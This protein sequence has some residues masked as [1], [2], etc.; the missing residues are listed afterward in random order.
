LHGELPHLSFLEEANKGLRAV[1]RSIQCTEAARLAADVE[2]ANPR[3]VPS[4]ALPASTGGITA[5]N[6]AK[7]KELL[8]AYGIRMPREEIVASS[9]EAVRAAESIGYPVVLKVVSDKI[10]HKSDIGGVAL[11]LRNSN[12]VAT[13]YRDIEL[14]VARHD[15]SAKRDGILVAEQVTGGTELVIGLH[16]DPEMGLVEMVGTGGILLE[17]IKDVSFSALPITN[18]KAMQMIARI[19]MSKLLS[20]YRGAIAGD[21]P[22][23][24]EALVALGHLAMDLGDRIESIDVNPLLVRPQ[25]HGAVAL[26]ALVVLRG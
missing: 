12:E 23:L 9:G 3:V 21:I 16:R 10:L 14:N 13:A 11:N 1:S 5:L 24:A 4:V 22:A 26:D 20:G 18:A 17:L 6:E 7:S 19:R 15:P 8:S 2:F 25:G